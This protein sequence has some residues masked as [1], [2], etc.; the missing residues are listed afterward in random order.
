M[1]G[2]VDVR[3]IVDGLCLTIMTPSF[4]C[5]Q[6]I[7]GAKPKDV[8]KDQVRVKMEDRA[9]ESVKSR[10][11]KR[12]A[13]DACDGAPESAQ[14]AARARSSAQSSTS[15]AASS[16]G[17]GE[18][19][20]RAVGLQETEQRRSVVLKAREKAKPAKGEVAPTPSPAEPPSEVDLQVS[21]H[22]PMAHHARSLHCASHPLPECYHSL[23]SLPNATAGGPHSQRHI[24]V[25]NCAGGGGGGGA[26]DRQGVDPGEDRQTAC[27][28]GPIAQPLSTVRYCVRGR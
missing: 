13:A 19:Q 18:V 15:P 5:E 9:A 28:V 23:P 1:C 8:A 16:E 6:G 7:R 10:P 22:M 2:V 25:H 26:V 20:R 12:R 4:S 14:G 27:A 21:L 17:G 3:V 24:V 11:P